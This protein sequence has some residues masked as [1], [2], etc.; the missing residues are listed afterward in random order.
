MFLCV[1]HA[2]F[3]LIYR[4]RGVPHSSV[5]TPVDGDTDHMMD[6]MVPMWAK[7]PF[8][9]T[10]HTE[11]FKPVIFI[12]E[13]A[14]L[15]RQWLNCLTCTWLCFIFFSRLS[16]QFLYPVAETSPCNAL[17]HH[18][19]TGHKFHSPLRILTD[20]L[21]CVVSTPKKKRKPNNSQ[22]ASIHVYECIYQYSNHTSE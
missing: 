4:V 1:L 12:L 5:P 8:H 10:C 14:Q 3:R 9:L 2:P 21:F 16:L 22:T 20:S 13:V 7:T 11:W 15:M 17:P 19:N 6:A 18:W